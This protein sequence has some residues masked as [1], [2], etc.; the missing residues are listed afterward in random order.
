[1]NA[2]NAAQFIPLVQAL[3]EGKTIQYKARHHPGEWQ[4]M[5]DVSFVDEPKDY[6]IKPEPRKFEGTVQ[7]TMRS[8]GDLE[9]ITIKLDGYNCDAPKT[10]TKFRLIEIL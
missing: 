1:M 2:N 6:R 4:D 8:N 9:L 5:N 7:S 3:V 10:G